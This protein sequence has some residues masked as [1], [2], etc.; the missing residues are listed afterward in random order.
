M[1]PRDHA[2]V[3]RA[4]GR[5]LDDLSWRHAC[6]QG[7]DHGIDHHLPGVLKEL[8]SLPVLHARLAE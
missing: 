2:Y 4:E 8:I 5:Q 6:P 1:F 7:P 3:G